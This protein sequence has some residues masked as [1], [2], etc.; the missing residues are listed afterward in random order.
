M[1][2]YCEYLYQM[3]ILLQRLG[4][5]LQTPDLPYNINNDALVPFLSGGLVTFVVLSIAHY[6]RR[7]R[8]YTREQRDD[9]QS[10]KT[11]LPY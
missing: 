6:H 8:T 3:N 1:D 2:N 5:T 9:V 10:E 4:G 7:W 11:K